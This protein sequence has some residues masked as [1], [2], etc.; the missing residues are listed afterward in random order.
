MKYL[1]GYMFGSPCRAVALVIMISLMGSSCIKSEYAKLVEQELAK[2]YRMDSVILG[3]HLGMSRKEFYSYCWAM[4]KQHIFTN[5]GTKV[6]YKFYDGDDTVVMK[7]YPDF[8]NDSIY[9][10]QAT[11]QYQG[12][13]P[14][15][16]HRQPDSLQVRL[17]KKFEKLSG[18]GF[19]KVERGGLYKDFAFVKVD[20]NRRIVM[21][22]ESEMELKTVFTDLRSEKR[23]KK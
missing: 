15:V 19:I 17:R 2:G 21:F 14:W 20:G 9:Q 23:I 13:M 16:L 6:L 11:Y 7:F 3:I 1:S 22:R 5:S 18:L 10:V 8:L 12:W 4:N